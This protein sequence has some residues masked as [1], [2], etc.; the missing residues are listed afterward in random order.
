MKREQQEFNLKVKIKEP[1]PT[2][3]DLSEADISS[4]IQF[5]QTLDEWD[6]QSRM[7]PSVDSK[8]SSL[9]SQPLSE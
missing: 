1:N 3:D 7:T 5:F 8:D 4:F 2:A 9:D 6:R